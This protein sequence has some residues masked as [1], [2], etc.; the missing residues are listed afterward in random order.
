MADPV[1]EKTKGRD[2]MD[3]GR[4]YGT[5]RFADIPLEAPGTGMEE[6]MGP[7]GWRGP[8]ITLPVRGFVHPVARKMADPGVKFR[9]PEFARVKAAYED[10]DLK[11]PE[12]VIKNRVTMLLMRM[13]KEKKL[14]SNDPVPVIVNKIFPAPGVIDETEFNNALDVT[15]RNLIYKSITDAYTNIKKEDVPAFR[16]MLKDAA[17]DVQTAA[18]DKTGLTQV[19]GS[20]D[21]EA[22]RNYGKIGRILRRLAAGAAAIARGFTTDYNLD[23]SQ[24][25]LGGSANFGS[26]T[27]HLEVDVVKV[28]DPKE[29]RVTVIHEAAHLAGNA[30]DDYGYYGEEGFFDLTEEKK[31][32]NAAHYEELPRRILNTSKYPNQIFAPGKDQSGKPITREGNIRED[33]S[34][35]LT[36]AWDAA[37][38]VHQFLRYVRWSYLE[39][40]N[41]PFIKSKKLILEISRLMDL[42][43]H[44]QA[45]KKAIVTTLDLTLTESIARAVMYISEYA[46]SVSFPN[47]VGNLTDE[48]L[49]DKIV[50]EAV[51]KYGNLMT[52]PARDKIL[53]DWL[54]DHYRNVW[55]KKR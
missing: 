4:T 33:V 34:N 25:V 35:Y 2:R 20:K 47:P 19:F 26:Q 7:A 27:M 51:K 5:S 48:A 14:K 16:T 1:Q 45:E 43:I 15:D 11:I 36:K 28:K 38:D 41:W 37:V 49:K 23:D 21:Q 53:L 30:I 29:S 46:K 52:S 9:L 24:V 12:A 31:I 6:I 10:P 44:E 13:E 8:L 18:A 42:T 40:S 3:A 54:S 22:K 55:P 50:E 17:A 39:K 32:V